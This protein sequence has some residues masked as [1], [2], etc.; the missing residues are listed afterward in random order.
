MKY[1]VTIGTGDEL[2]IDVN[3]RPGGRLDV[4]VDG[5]EA[6]VDVV[7]A[8]GAISV[9]VGHRVFDLWLEGEDAKFRVMVDGRRTTAIVQSDRARVATQAS[10]SGGAVGDEV[11]APMPGRV[12]KWLVALGEHVGPK[13]PV[14]VIEAMKME[15][16]ICT[17]GGGVV[18]ELG[19]KA[20]ENVESGMVLLRLG[21]PGEEK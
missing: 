11:C 20:G 4:T 15:N 14:V 13:T 18:T 7:D 17:E 3:R 10:R 6:D 1:Y 16:E 9:K 21:D 5:R 8:D 2:A 12:V 19:V